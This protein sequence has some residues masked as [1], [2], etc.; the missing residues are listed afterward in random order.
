MKK[1]ADLLER[2]L[3]DEVFEKVVAGS[4]FSGM[5]KTYD[6]LEKS[7][8]KGIMYT[9]AGGQMPFMQKGMITMVVMIMTMMIIMMKMIMIIMMIVVVIIII[10]I[11][12]F[13]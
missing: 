12:G 2:S 9:R 7:S 6:A 1:V 5:K 10:I 3:T 4:E 13:I 8:E 11:I